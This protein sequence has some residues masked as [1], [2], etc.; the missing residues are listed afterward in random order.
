MG[1][2][3]LFILRMN[4]MTMTFIFIVSV[5]KDAEGCQLN[6]YNYNQ[7]FENTVCALTAKI[8]SSIVAQQLQVTA[9]PHI[10]IE[11]FRVDIWSDIQ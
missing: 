9:Q 3:T 10:G 4:D 2:N 8:V 1:S 7:P 11:I 5:V 6:L